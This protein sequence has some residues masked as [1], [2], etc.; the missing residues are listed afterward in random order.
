MPDILDNTDWGE[1]DYNQGLSTL[2]FPDSAEKFLSHACQ[3]YYHL[4]QEWGLC[5]YSENT[6]F[7]I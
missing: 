5:M 6:D 1:F 3:N 2:F 7:E 4:I